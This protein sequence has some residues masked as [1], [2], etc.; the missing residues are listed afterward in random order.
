M[1]FA[2]NPK[3]HL[4]TTLINLP[5]TRGAALAATRVRVPSHCSTN[6]EHEFY[7]G[8]AYK[9]HCIVE[10]KSLSQIS[11]TYL[12]HGELIFSYFFLLLPSLTNRRPHSFQPLS[13][14]CILLSIT[15]NAPYN[16]S[17]VG[18]EVRVPDD[19]K[20]GPMFVPS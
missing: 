4:D 19:P 7:R 18:D 13:V 2:S 11:L 12:R 1:Q 10:K 9:S 20:N 3:K 17:F 5:N 14:A 15:P 6:T 8:C 16:R